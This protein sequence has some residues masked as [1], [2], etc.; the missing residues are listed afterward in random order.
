MITLS[1]DT[2]SIEI[3]NPE[4]NYVSTVRIAIEP[5]R[6]SSG[7]DVV[8]NGIANDYRTCTMHFILDEGDGA[9]LDEFIF[10]HRQDTINM[11][12]GSSSGVCPFCPDKGDSGTFTV[13]IV[14]R[15]YGPFD[16]FKQF[17]KT[18]KFLM[19]TAPEYE[20]PSVTNQDNFQIG[21]VDGLLYPQSG[22]DDNRAFGIQTRVSYGGDAYSV[23][24]RDNIHTVEFVQRCNTG[25]AAELVSFL[26]GASGRHQDITVI[27]PDDYYLFGIENGANGTYTCKLIQTELQCRHVENEHFEIPLRFYM[28][29]AV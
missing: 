22:I 15:K 18:V 28:K 7:W 14:E 23:D 27:A 8:N 20:L 11:N 3:D 6:L 19:V 2:D 10:N 1:Y 13:K 16:Q 5:V 25:L 26:T 9:D 24:V 21:T 12:V 17:G 29:E 4:N